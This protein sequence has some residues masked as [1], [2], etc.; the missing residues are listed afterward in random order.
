[1]KAANIQGI[2]DFD[3]LMGYWRVEHRR[4]KSRLCNCTEWEEF[5]GTSHAQ[6]I[7]GDMGNIDDNILNIP[8]GAYRAVTLR[9]FD[10]ET[11]QW[12]IWWL[13]GR[14]PGQLDVP[15]KGKF[16]DGIGS[17]F[18]DDSL[19]GRKIRVRFL[20]TTH[21]PNQPTWEQAFSID[22]GKTWETNWFMRF[23]RVDEN[24]KL[25]K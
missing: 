5:G 8:S 24:G 7:L 17:F 13:D 2:N 14:R 21:I 10:V 22:G 4:L 15:V 20:W 9:S 12:S 6:K 1:M 25:V 16:E 3:F 11:N 19:D 18:A 23:E